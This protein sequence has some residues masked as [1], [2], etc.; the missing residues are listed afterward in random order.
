MIYNLFTTDMKRIRNCVLFDELLRTILA[1][2][3]VVKNFHSGWHNLQLFH[4]FS[5]DKDGTI[6][7]TKPWTFWSLIRVWFNPNYH[8]YFIISGFSHF[9]LLWVLF[10]KKHYNNLV[11]VLFECI[12][13]VDKFPLFN[14]TFIS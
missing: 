2:L 10:Y 4:T 13:K 11:H 12:C 14:R 5:R 9:F 7:E 8:C 1:V 6:S 3:K